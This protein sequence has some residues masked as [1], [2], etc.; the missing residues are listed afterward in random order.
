VRR[1]HRR[2]GLL[3]VGDQ[4]KGTVGLYV[5]SHCG[6]CGYGIGS[7]DPVVL[8]N[9]KD[10]LNDESLCLKCFADECGDEGSATHRNLGGRISAQVH[11]S[12]FHGISTL[13]FCPQQE[14]RH[15]VT[16]ERA[17]K[18]SPRVARRLNDKVCGIGGCTCGD[19]IA[20]QTASGAEGWVAAEKYQ[21]SDRE[22][23]SN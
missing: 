22:R 5:D 9:S 6:L 19:K 17:Y 3:N 8:V 2:G 1:K 18:V 12:G 15:P 14:G 20:F 4:V 21:T 23:R 11:Y 10:V 16:G 7:E 13:R